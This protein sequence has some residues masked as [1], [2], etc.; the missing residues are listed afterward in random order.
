MG[1][2]F[3]SEIRKGPCPLHIPSAKLQNPCCPW[4]K[5][6]QTAGDPTGP[7]APWPSGSWS[8]S[9][10]LYGDEV[11]SGCGANWAGD[12]MTRVRAKRET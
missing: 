10:L 7:A 11:R 6:E 1:R 12:V 8:C 4:S 2:E 9:A 3:F 5:E